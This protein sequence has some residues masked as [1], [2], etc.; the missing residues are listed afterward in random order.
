MSSSRRW[1]TG[2]TLSD[3]DDGEWGGRSAGLTD[4]GVAAV[5]WAVFA[6]EV[7]ALAMGAVTRGDP[8]SPDISGVVTSLAS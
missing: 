2:Q 6:I 1:V 8:V 7:D 3:S 5:D 4:F